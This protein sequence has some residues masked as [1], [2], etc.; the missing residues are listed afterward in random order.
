MWFG[1]STLLFLKDMARVVRVT[2][3]EILCGDWTDPK[4]CRVPVLLGQGNRAG[5][6]FSSY[7]LFSPG[8]SS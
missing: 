6:I 2:E 7:F 5:I 8:F 1:N 4:W 3:A